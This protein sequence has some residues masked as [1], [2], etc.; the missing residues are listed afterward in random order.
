M[1]M[2]RLFFIKAN[3]EMRQIIDAFTLFGKRSGPKLNLEKT[4]AMGLG[5]WTQIKPRENISN[6][7]RE[8]DPN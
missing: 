2:T 5:K 4:L 8:V 1:S 3:Y 6:G 7:T